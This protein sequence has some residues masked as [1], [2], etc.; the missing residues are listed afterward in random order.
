MEK[1]INKH[2]KSWCDRGKVMAM[3]E[4]K[5]LAFE[6]TA[7]MLLGC[8]FSQSQM[9]SMMRNME[10]MVKNFFT[11]PIDLPGFGFHKVIVS[12]G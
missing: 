4:S 12:Y 9:D 7:H 10:V 6:T 5:K 11:L 1:I 8:D 3:E 2:M